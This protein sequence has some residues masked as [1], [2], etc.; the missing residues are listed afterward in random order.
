MELTY[1]Q[2]N[3]EGKHSIFGIISLVLGIFGVVLSFFIFS[4]L[5]IYIYGDIV[6]GTELLRDV[7]N[8]GGKIEVVIKPLG[9]ILGIVGLFQKNKIKTFAVIGVII[10]IIV[11]VWSLLLRFGFII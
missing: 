1:N 10:N 9:L 6:I 7:W 5:W 8:I 11:I 4:S 3:K 2:K